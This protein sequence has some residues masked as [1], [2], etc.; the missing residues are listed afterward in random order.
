MKVIL[1]EDVKNVGKKDQT[2]NAS[3]GYAKNY[4][5][6]KK[7]AVEATD[8]N[9]KKLDRKKADEAAKAAEELEKA[10]K[11]CAEIEAKTIDIKV[12]VGGN[13]KLFGAVTNKEISAALKE[14]FDLDIDKKKITVEPIKNV[15]S[16][17]AVI[18][19][20]PQVSAKLKISVSEQ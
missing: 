17:E 9:I 1:L 7:L 10:K 18:K 11:L 8:A 13:G 19:L 4:L 6:P 14:Q 5:I 15:G 3:D 12:K 2:I 20:H 16:S